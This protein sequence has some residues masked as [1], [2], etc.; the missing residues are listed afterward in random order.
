VTNCSD[1]FTTFIERISLKQ[2]HIDRIESAIGGLTDHLSS[3]LDIEKDAIFTQGSY[4]NGTAIRP[5]ESGAYDVDLI[6]PSADSEVSAKRALDDLYTAIGDHGR[7][8]DRLEAKTPCVRVNY[9]DDDIGSF[10]VDVVPVRDSQS[11]EAPLDAPRRNSGWH[12]TAPAEF[13]DWCGD[14]GD[15]FTR[16]VKALKRWRNEQQDVEKAI[17]SIVLQVLT[18]DHMPTWV[19]DD[20]DRLTQT[21]ES[22]S[23]A[24]STA[25]E[26]PQVLN[27]VLS[28]ENLT[29]RWSWSHFQDFQAKLSDAAC[30]ARAAYDESDAITS[31]QLWKELLG[32]QFPLPSAEKS[33]LLLA[34]QSHRQS[35]ST[36]SWTASG[37]PRIFALT[38]RVHSGNGGRVIQESYQGGALKAGWK[39]KFTADYQLAE[40][41]EI[42]WQVVNTGAHAESSRALRG[43]FSYATRRDGTPSPDSRVNWESTRY[44]GSHLIQAFAVDRLGQVTSRSEPFRVDI[45]DP[46]WRSVRR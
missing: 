12:A 44:T 4:A 24:L 13:T 28:S 37:D 18:N 40:G 5:P 31:A 36:K 19:D 14:R 27:P 1:E 41:E 26:V 3:Q 6:V 30:A 20:A 25:L 46:L 32:I 15:R 8:T 39:I 9:A 21:L 11:D 2:R 38:A 22:M 35:L 34:D 17:K 29:K 42:W 45:R 16:T 33:N 10:H 23:A 7:Y 43:G